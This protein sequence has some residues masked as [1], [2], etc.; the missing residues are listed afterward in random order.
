MLN[1]TVNGKLLSTK[2][3]AASCYP[4]LEQDADQCEYVDESWSD[5]VFQASDP[6]GLSYPINITCAPVNASSGEQPGA[7]TLGNQPLYAVNATNEA[8]IVAAVQF[9]ARTNIRVVIKETGHDILGRSEGGSSL[10]I[11]TRYLRN[12]LEF[13][14]SYQ[15]PCGATC[16]STTWTGAAIN[17]NGG[18]TWSDVYPVA[19]ANGK[20]VV[21]GG[22]PSVSTTGGWMQGGG[23]GPASR[24]FGLGA[25]QVLS[26]RVVLADGCIITASPCENQDI[27]FAIRGGGPG[28]YGVVLSTTI[29]AW[30]IVDVKVQSV[31]IAPL[32]TNTSALLDAIAILYSA[33]PDLNDAG[34]AG[35]GTWSIASPGPIF[36]NFTA[37]YVHGFYTFNKTTEATQDAFA[38]TLEKLLPFNGTSLFVSVTYNSFDDYWTFYNAV[39]GVEPPVGTTS[40]LGSR[41]FSRASVQKNTLDLRNMIDVIAGEPA[42]FTSN[43][44][45]LVSGGQVFKDAADPLSGL[46][47]AWR[48]SYFNNIVARG[49]AP[50]SSEDVKTAVMRDITYNKVPAMEKQ[51]PDTGVY[52]NEGYRLDPNWQTNFYGNHYE[53]LLEIKQTRDPSGIFYCPTCVGSAAW[54]EDES[55]RLCKVS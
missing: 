50:G 25:D 6:V 15:S 7:C 27:Y 29:K 33:Y 43:N 49:W 11:W 48:I 22:T 30:P 2:P 17:I 31:A 32:A 13:L 12:G 37:G 38:S 34:Y 47:P 42:E 26:A 36:A 1:S 4:G 46:N 24:A 40:G 8:D 39:S 5:A 54:K 9:A 35:Y 53:R 28:T 14:E 21:G 10:L 44:F 19:Q 23:H 16:N 52:M 51:A 3:I 55:G 41:L 45:E 18:Y 20:V